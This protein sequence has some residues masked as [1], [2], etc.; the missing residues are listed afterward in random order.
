MPHFCNLGL[1]FTSTAFERWSCP[2]M[3]T[4]LYWNARLPAF[5]ACERRARL[6]PEPSKR[7]IKTEGE[8]NGR[9]V[10]GENFASSISTLKFLCTLILKP[11]N[12]RVFRLHVGVLRLSKY[13]TCSYVQV[14]VRQRA[15]PSW[16]LLY[17]NFPNLLLTSISEP[18]A[19]HIARHSVTS[20]IHFQINVSVSRHSVMIYELY[21][22]ALLHLSFLL[23][24]PAISDVPQRYRPYRQATS[25]YRLSRTKGF[26]RPAWRG[27]RWRAA[28]PS[29]EICRKEI[30]SQTGHATVTHHR[31]D[32]HYEL[33]W[34]Q[35]SILLKLH[36]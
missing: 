17:Q 14:G 36:N 5:L 2:W 19:G 31:H 16:V 33:Y 23:A 15:T 4:L 18:P 20:P 28:R 34:C 11:A 12:F 6:R 13:N 8:S 25:F 27:W 3:D 24:S 22:K 30:A 26:E 7:C 10:R 21:S 9:A 35:S 32:F 1:A 29:E